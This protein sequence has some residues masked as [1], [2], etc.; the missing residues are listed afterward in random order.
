MRALRI[1]I[2]QHLVENLGLSLKHFSG[3]S[4]VDYAWLGIRATFLP[5]EQAMQPPIWFL[6]LSACASVGGGL[7]VFQTAPTV[8]CYI[9]IVVLAVERI[10]FSLFKRRYVSHANTQTQQ[11]QQTQSQS[12]KQATLI[13]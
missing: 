11:T 2:I 12:S 10:F 6:G 13:L 9:V 8:R 4:S 5:R 3:V 7:S 1:L